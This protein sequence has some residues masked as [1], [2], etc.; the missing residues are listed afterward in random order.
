DRTA[1]KVPE[2][3]RRSGMIRVRMGE[4]DQP[5]FGGIPAGR[6]DV[7]RDQL[8]RPVKTG[9]DD[10]NAVPVDEVHVHEPAGVRSERG[11]EGMDI[12]GDL[13]GAT[14]FNLTL[15]PIKPTGIPSPLRQGWPDIRFFLVHTF[16][17]FRP[18]LR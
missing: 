7:I 16:I 8:L 4:D 1:R 11:F 14:S 10:G 6:T 18:S 9:I 15:S 17:T 13:H 5:D 2:C 3:M 12:R